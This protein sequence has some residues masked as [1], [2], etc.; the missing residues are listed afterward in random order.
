MGTNF[1]PRRARRNTKKRNSSCSFVYFVDNLLLRGPLWMLVLA[2]TLIAG[3]KSTTTST[4]SAQ[5]NKSSRPEAAL[6]PLDPCPERLHDI[7]GALLNFL[8][9]YN[10]LPPSLEDLTPIKGTSPSLNCPISNQRYIYNPTGIKFQANQWAI[11][12]DAAPSHSNMRW[13]IV[14]SERGEGKAPVPSVV[15]ISEADFRS[16]S[17]IPGVPTR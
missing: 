17:G 7:A 11:V 13:A 2:V 8:I 1:Y 14:F 12:Y 9:Q 16:V 6:S 3:C 5:P 10:R 4:T 15:A